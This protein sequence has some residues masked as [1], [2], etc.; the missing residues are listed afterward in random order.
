MNLYDLIQ[1]IPGFINSHIE[2]KAE[3]SNNVMLGGFHLGKR[4]D[5][6]IWQS[7]NH[8]PVFP[9][10]WE[11]EVKLSKVSTI[12]KTTDLSTVVTD[13]GF[14]LYLKPDKKLK[15]ISKLVGWFSLPA[16][17]QIKRNLDNPDSVT[18]IWRSEDA[19]DDEKPVYRLLMQ[20]ANECVNLIVK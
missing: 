5:M 3:G 12:Y 6:N 20:N 11:R 13:T 18:F 17:E 7:S 19:E 9:C 10:Q 1:K 16:L 8:S 14:V 4:Y 2:R 15:N